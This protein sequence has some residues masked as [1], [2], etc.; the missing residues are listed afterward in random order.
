MSDLTVR[1]PLFGGQGTPSPFT[2]DGTGS[3]RVSDA[4]GRY[5]EAAR[6]KQVFYAASQAATA[7]SVALTT[8]Y[9]GLVV[10]NP[11]NSPVNLEI[12][13]VGFALSV[14]PVAIAHIG[15]FSGFLA[16]GITVH[17]TALVPSSTFIGA[18]PG[19][20]KADA[21]A[22]LV[23]TPVWVDALGSGFTAGALY[24]TTPAKVDLAGLFVIPPGGYFGIGALTAV[25][26]FGSVQWEEVPIIAST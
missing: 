20:G 23:G 17:T 21:A 2:S 10:Y 24:A 1:G 25:T 7:W 9:T 13:Q 5:A 26:G 15:L 11:V 4:H 8:T 19:Y 14:A 22:T 3:Q 16:A 6:R 12:L 18:P